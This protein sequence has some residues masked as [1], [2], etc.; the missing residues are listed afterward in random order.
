MA[1]VRAVFGF[2]LALPAT[3]LCNGQLQLV[4]K[5]EQGKGVS[6]ESR[7]AVNVVVSAY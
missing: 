2:F 3:F 1:R 4:K 5:L 7:V 6:S